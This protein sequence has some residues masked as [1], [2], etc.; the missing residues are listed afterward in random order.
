MRRWWR[1]VVVISRR[2]GGLV[3]HLRSDWREMQVRAFFPYCFLQTEYRPKHAGFLVP[4]PFV[5]LPVATSASAV[6]N[7][8][9]RARRW[10]RRVPHACH[11]QHPRS[12]FTYCLNNLQT[13]KLLWT[14]L[15]GSHQPRL[16]LEPPAQFGGAMRRSG[17]IAKKHAFL[18]AFSRAAKT[19]RWR[20]F[21]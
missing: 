8:A 7:R 4:S 2:G 3:A 6:A 18:Y 5:R 17:A 12:R 13:R 14:K 21:R 10:T 9:L 19:P 20:H 11:F 15:R 16:G 1:G